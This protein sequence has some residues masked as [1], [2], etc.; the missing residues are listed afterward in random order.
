M[1]KCTIIGKFAFNNNVV[2]GQTVKCSTIYNE[3]NDT[4]GIENIDYIDTYSWEKKIFRTLIKSYKALRNSKNIII[5]PAQKGIKFFSPFLSFFNLLYKKKLHYVVIGSWLYEKINKNFI[6]KK[7]LKKFDAIYV[8]TTLLK[9]KLEKMG[10]NNI[11]L[12]NN[13][14][15]LKITKR[16]QQFQEKK[17]IKICTFSRVNY[18]KGIE[19]IIT[20]IKKLNLKKICFLLDIYGQIDE[21]YIDRFEQVVKENKDYVKYKGLAEP[22]K[23]VQILKKY[24]LLA[25]PTKYYTE[26]IPGTIIDSYASGLPV[27]T[28]KWENYRDV[29]DDKITG[30]CYEFN[31]LNDL[32]KKLLYAYNNQIKIYLM[33]KNCLKKAKEYC[34]KEILNIL[35]KNME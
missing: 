24:D 31:D 21:N 7:S 35:L 13:Y 6:L 25:F 22:N 11:Y 33:K 19:D 10:F 18:N 3:L 2:D 34:S 16:F 23:S 32:E 27:V 30:I 12:M 4:Y 9:N 26:G 28:S 8:E 15:N 5:L 1:K 20:V 14:K 29:I 17:I